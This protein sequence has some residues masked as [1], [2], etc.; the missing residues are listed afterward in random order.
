MSTSVD[1]A[2]AVLAKL[3]ISEWNDAIEKVF[4]LRKEREGRNRDLEEA[5]R[6]L[7]HKLPS[8]SEFSSLF[9][10]IVMLILQRYVKTIFQQLSSRIVAPRH[11]ITQHR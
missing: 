11:E 10:M 9:Y 7:P 3:P 1:H 8:S 2:I 6:G 5:E 4:A